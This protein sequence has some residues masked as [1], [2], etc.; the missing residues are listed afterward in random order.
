MRQ[1][2][3]RDHYGTQRGLDLEDSDVC[4]AGEMRLERTGECR[5]TRTF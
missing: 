5:P 3:A 1:W 4:G 2:D